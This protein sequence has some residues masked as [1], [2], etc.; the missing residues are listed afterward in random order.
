MD[1][2]SAIKHGYAG[3]LLIDDKGTI[4]LLILHLSSPYVTR[5]GAGPTSQG[6]FAKERDNYQAANP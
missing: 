4:D 1:R 6:A 2:G 5:M 3:W